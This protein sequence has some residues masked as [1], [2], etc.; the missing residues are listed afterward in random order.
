MPSHRSLRIAEAVREVV[1]TA[2]LFDVADPRV[3]SV[4]VLGVDVA[5]DMRTARVRVTIMGNPKEQKEAFQ[6]LRHAA[7]F[8]QARVAARLQ[9]RFTPVLDFQIDDSVKK[10]VEMARLIDAAV[11]S[12]QK[13]G[14]PDDA[15]DSPDELAETANLTDVAPD[16]RLE[17]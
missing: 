5:P 11:A 4:T 16:H 17:V 15:T 9:T 10:S 12:D 6:G 1:A 2:I 7:G 8:L 13:P 3:R 14:E